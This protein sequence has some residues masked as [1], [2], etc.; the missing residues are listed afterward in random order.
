MQNLSHVVYADDVLIF[1]KSKQK[2]DMNQWDSEELHSFLFFLGLE[3]NSEKNNAYYSMA[4]ED[5][6]QVHAILGFNSKA[7]LLTYLGLPISGKRKSIG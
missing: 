2:S 7:L 4:T 1:S 3:V 6:T 5:L